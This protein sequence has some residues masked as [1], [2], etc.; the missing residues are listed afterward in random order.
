MSDL[1]SGLVAAR[2]LMRGVPLFFCN[3]PRTPLRVLAIIALDTVH[4]LRSS[5]PMPRKRLDELALVLDFQACTNAAWDRKQVCQEEY[6][7][8][9]RR[10]EQ[11]GL[12]RYLDEYLGHL[13][14]LERRRPPIGADRRN[15]ED[16]RAYR[17]AVAWLSLATLADIALGSERLDEDEDLNTL[18]RMAMQC[19][20]VDDV[21]DYPAD[22][23]AG[24]PSYL[25]ALAS[26][27]EALEL[28]AHAARAYGRRSHG[29]YPLR[30][31]LHILSTVARL[32]VRRARRS[33]PIT[34]SVPHEPALA[35]V[36]PAYLLGSEDAR[37]NV[38]VH[39]Q[40]LGTRSVPL[41]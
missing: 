40:A 19:Q 36:D 28:T 32:V 16:V 34:R 33:Q 13:R 6:Q 12:G 35:G 21:W 30:I 25:T 2:C 31:A 29:A 41:L 17:E 1:R 38:E 39:G 9:R 3:A 5:R 18:F 22:L 24:L 7:A 20:I 14:E 27:S 10:L 8:S 37:S 4:T 23:C 15:F 11:V 26:L